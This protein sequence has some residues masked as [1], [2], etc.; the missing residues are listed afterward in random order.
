[1]ETKE[2]GLTVGPVTENLYKSL[3]ALEKARNYYYCAFE[4]EGGERFGEQY[5]ADALKK[6]GP[7]FDAV[8]DM[9]EREITDAARMWAYTATATNVI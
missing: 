2:T 8:R 9:L 7:L 3:R 6:N 4:A 5:A 1:M